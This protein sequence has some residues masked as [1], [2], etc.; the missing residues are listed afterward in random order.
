MR[1]SVRLLACCAL[2]ALAV[3]TVP[4]FAKAPAPGPTVEDVLQRARL[5]EAAARQKALDASKDPNKEA[6]EGY[7]SKKTALGDYQKLVELLLDGDTKELQEYR[8]PAAEALVKRFEL[9]DTDNNEK[10]RQ[11]RVDIALELLPLLTASPKDAV[12]LAAAESIYYAWYRAQ[13]VNNHWKKDAK[14]SDRQ[15]ATQ[16]IRKFLRDSKK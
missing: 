12:G 14:L 4:A 16:R 5:D 3:A 2:G 15:R 9:E 7:K 1:M 6:I 11:T 13:L 8:A 10:T